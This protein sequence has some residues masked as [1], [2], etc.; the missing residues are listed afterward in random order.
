MK[1]CPHSNVE[2]CPLYHAAH[3][4]GLGCDDGE[5]WQGTCGIARG[6]SYS[7]QLELIK[8]NLPGV[9]ERCAWN[10]DLANRKA[11]RSRNLMLNGIH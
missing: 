5:L 10:E 7:Q 3:Y 8:V 9:A 4:G 11:Q 2:H 6:V 1:H